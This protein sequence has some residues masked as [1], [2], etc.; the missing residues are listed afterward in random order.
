MHPVSGPNPGF[1]NRVRHTFTALIVADR[2]VDRIVLGRFVGLAGVAAKE[3]EPAAAEASLTS[4]A[5]DIVMI[6][7]GPANDLHLPI[8]DGMA[9]RA[10]PA[11]FVVFSSSEVARQMNGDP[12]IDVAIC[13]PVT[14]DKIVPAIRDLI[15]ARWPG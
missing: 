10:R 1:P 8:V 14:T 9:G 4:S 15:D 11:T 3:V 6:D 13:K 5:F 12:R 2:A 7:A